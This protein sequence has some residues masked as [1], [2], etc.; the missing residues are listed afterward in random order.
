[1][2][3]RP[4]PSLSAPPAYTG[5]SPPAARLAACKDFLAAE[6]GRIRQRHRAGES[7]QKI[8]SAIAAMID[9]L[10]HP[11]FAHAH[12][13]WR[14]SHGEP[15]SPVCLIALG[16][17]GRSELN[18]LSDIDV[19][20]LYPSAAKSK[21]LARFQEH[22]SNGILYPLWDLGL[23]IGHSTR[24]LN[25]V[26]SDAVRDIRT[27]TSLLE[28]HLIAGAETLYENFAAAYRQHYLTDN[29]NAY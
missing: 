3:G 6:S 29:P 23:K 2:T 9:R 8:V 16:G 15:P 12:G 27:K 22:L 20:F 18:P 26:F 25:E 4:P 5:D 13:D 10:L 7:G 19:M 11:L 14:K 17:Y 1:M 28:S 21:E 24:T